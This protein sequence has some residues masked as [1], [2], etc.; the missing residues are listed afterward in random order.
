VYVDDKGSSC[1]SWLE[2]SAEIDNKASLSS[3]VVLKDWPHNLLNSREKIGWTKIAFVKS[4]YY[5][6][7]HKK[8][9]NQNIFYD[10]VRQA[11]Q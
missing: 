8:Y 10:S 9:T 3:D 6:L 7:R 2:L 11:I 5:L 1:K 4:F